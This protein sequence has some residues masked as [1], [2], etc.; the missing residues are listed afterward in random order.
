MTGSRLKYFLTEVF[1]ILFAGCLMFAGAQT[2]SDR[3]ISLVE[4]VTKVT[5]SLPKEIL[6]PIEVKLNT[7]RPGLFTHNPPIFEVASPDKKTAAGTIDGALYIRQIN[8]DEKKII[9][10]PRGAKKWDVQGALWS[11]DGKLL[12]LKLTDETGVP[13]IPLIKWDGKKEEVSLKPY[14]RAG[15]KLPLHELYIV[16]VESRKTTTVEHGNADPYFHILDWNAE[17][18]TIY[19][20]RSDR[21]N[22]RLDLLA[23]NADT[24]KAT[25]VFTE[26]NKFGGQWWHMIHGYDAQM[27]SNNLVKILKNGDF[28]WTSERSGFAHLYLY[29]R[30]AKLIRSLTE[31][32]GAGFVER[33]VRVDEKRGYIYVIT[34][35]ANED[36]LYRQSLYRF[37]LTDG[38]A[39]KLA[40]A[41]ELRAT[42]SDDMEKMWVLRK[43]A[44]EL[45]QAETMKT[46]GSDRQVFWK[47]DIS[48]LKE[49]GFSPEYL[50]VT[51]ADGKTRLRSVIIK[52]KDFDPKKSYPVLENIYAGPNGTVIPSSFTGTPLLRGQELAN[53]GFIV[54]L[55]DGRGTPGRGQAFQNYAAGRFGEVEIADHAAV[56][57]ALARKRKYMDLS[58]V[59]VFGVSWGGYFTLRALLQEPEL[60]RA[61]AVLAGATDTSSMRVPIESFM[62]CLPA[63][64]LGAYKAG[65]NL[66]QIEKLKAPL[67]VSHGTYDD[68]VPIT[69]SLKLVD[70]L[71]K[72][73]KDYE[74]VPLLGAS[75]SIINANNIHQKV[76]EFFEKQFMKVPK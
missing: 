63:D 53:R 47:A 17:G 24:G 49:Y 62:G 38:R 41:S 69:E 20:L 54:V 16:D 68:D 13:L 46:D 23:A 57:R 14:S 61:G 5:R 22:R 67:F 37:Q 56:L 64:C 2:P 48:F 25:T 39:E 71:Q 8:G 3:Q 76:G 60:Y 66:N 33:L 1:T 42:F 55:I 36:D 19:F 50:N 34:Q 18:D 28:I 35:G 52:P 73:G 30:D 70:A 9:V 31:G 43:S 4:R 29:D 75:H 65:D 72:A 45:Y 32:K 10:K 59:G 51:A 44:P 58:R 7:V 40:E 12:A 11:P 15:E 26:T 6:P 74:F 27:S 21:L